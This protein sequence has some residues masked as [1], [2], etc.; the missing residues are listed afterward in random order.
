MQPLGRPPKMQLLRHCDEVTELTKLHDWLHGAILAYLP[1]LRQPR[2]A[3]LSALSTIGDRQGQSAIATT[4][5]YTSPLSANS[6]RT[7]LG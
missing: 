3:P 7:I 1:Q 5:F 4:H 2:T 6:I